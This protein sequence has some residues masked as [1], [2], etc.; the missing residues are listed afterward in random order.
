LADRA[1]FLTLPYVHDTRRRPE[2]EIWQ[3]F[4]TARSY[5][6]GALLEAAAN[7]K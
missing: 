6:L 1:I 3:E 5:F 4:E 2:R 7:S